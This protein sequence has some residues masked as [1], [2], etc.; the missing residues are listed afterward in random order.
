MASKRRTVG[1]IGLGHMGWPMAR[2]LASGDT[3]LVVFDMCESITAAAAEEIG[4]RAA[5]TSREVG[6]NADVVVL[7]LP[8]GAIVRDVVLG[9]EPGQGL[10]DTMPS[11]VGVIIDMSSS[12]PVGTKGLGEDV[13]AY[14]LTLIDAPVSG[15]V[16]KAV[17]GEL[18]IMVG[19][20]PTAVESVQWL[21]QRM[22]KKIFH[23]G[24]L[25][26]G[27]AMKALNNYVSAAGLVA[28]ADAVRIGRSFGLEAKTVVDI[29]NAS[30]G[31]NNSTKNKFHQ[32][33]LSGTYA[34]GF[35]LSLMAKDL[36]IAR[37]ISH[38]LHHSAPILESCAR[39]WEEAVTSLENQPDHTEIFRFL[40]ERDTRQ[41]GQNSRSLSDDQKS[42]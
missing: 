15:G 26:A 36:G 22:G 31:S 21:L 13:A 20:G 14:G 27:H 32:F 24:P 30:S 37:S 39:L 41:G 4:A 6:N 1:F 3:G 16:K 19:G 17:S 28:A 7:M 2:N 10:V 18:A 11:T 12:D 33:I 40:E 38:A 5:A 42:H 29:L 23:A 9:L 25:G 8:N 34:S 35:S